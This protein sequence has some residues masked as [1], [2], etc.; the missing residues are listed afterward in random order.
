MNKR[1]SLDDVMNISLYSY[2]QELPS[3]CKKEIIQ[4]AD[5]RKD[6]YIH[7]EE[8]TKI[9]HNIGASNSVSKQELRDII[10]ELGDSHSH[11]INIHQM[12]NI[13]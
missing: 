9:V 10:D 11:T 3:R 1:S 13:L 2:A 12:Y 5:T 7:E 8:F 4:A 6:G